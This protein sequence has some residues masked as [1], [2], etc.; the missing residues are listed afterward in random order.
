MRFDHTALDPRAKLVFLLGVAIVTLAVPTVR[1]LAILAGIVVLVLAFGRGY[2]IADLARSLS[3]LRLLVPIILVLNSF[4]YVGGTVFWSV[5]LRLF[6]LALSTGGLTTSAVIAGRLVILAGVAAWFA[7]TTDS[8]AF[9]VAL[10]RLGL[11]WGFA[12]MLSLTLRLV[13]ELRNRFRRIEDAQ[14]ARGLTF[15]G[16]PLARARRRIPM[17]IPFLAAVIRYGNELGDALTVRD[18]GRS[19]QRTYTVSIAFDRVDYLL[20]LFGIAM[21]VAF[22]IGFRT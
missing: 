4:F 19:R 5:D 6:T 12:F 18:F 11:P 10:V 1:S 7:T 8:E 2:G 17:L 15:E 3:P 20:S 14:R 16:G 9:E 22:V 13:P 21:V